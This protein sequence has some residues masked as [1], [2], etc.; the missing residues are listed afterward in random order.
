MKTAE[1]SCEQLLSC[2]EGHGAA[3]GY[4]M[5]IGDLEDFLRAALA[6][7]SPEQLDQFWDD[8]RVQG[9]V[10]IIIEYQGLAA[11]IYGTTEEDSE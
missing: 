2:A 3:E 1:E 8:P 9:T 11:E 4:E 5:W 6:L 10:S 7:L